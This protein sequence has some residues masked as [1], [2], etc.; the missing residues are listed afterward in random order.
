MSK[1]SLPVIAKAT[2]KTFDQTVRHLP[3]VGKTARKL[4]VSPTTALIGTAIGL[5]L[6]GGLWFF[7]KLAVLGGIGF[8]TYFVNEK[9]KNN[10]IKKHGIG[11]A[12]LG[13]FLYF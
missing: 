11:A 5:S 1:T 13:A 2:S 7:L 8:H 6:F 10:P 9:T 3:V 4:P 12:L